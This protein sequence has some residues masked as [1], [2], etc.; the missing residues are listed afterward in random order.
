MQTAIMLSQGDLLSGKEVDY[1]QRFVSDMPEDEKS[2]MDQFLAFRHSLSENERKLT[3][4]S[5]M[6]TQQVPDCIH[7]YLIKHHDSIAEWIASSPHDSSVDTNT[8]TVKM[9]HQ[10]MSHLGGKAG[11][12]K[13]KSEATKIKMSVSGK[14]GGKAIPSEEA[15]NKMRIAKTTWTEAELKILRDSLEELGTDWNRIAERIPGRS[16]DNVYRRW[17]QFERHI[18]ANVDEVDGRVRQSRRDRIT[19]HRAR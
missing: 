11:K 8:I 6:T 19:A 9:L 10:Y 5:E 2:V 3:P 7:H 16:R 1:I 17:Y 15:R 18:M 13:K 12:G 4:I 14:I